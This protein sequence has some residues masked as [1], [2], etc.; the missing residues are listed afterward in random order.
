MIITPTVIGLVLAI[1]GVIAWIAGSFKIANLE[2]NFETTKGLFV[3]IF[4]VLH[5]VVGLLLIA[6]D[7]I[8]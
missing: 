7:L 3:F 4:A 8:F 1:I 2:I 5:V 6:I